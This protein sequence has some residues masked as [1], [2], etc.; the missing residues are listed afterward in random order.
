MI[1]LNEI[2]RKYS[3]GEN[4][5]FFN[6]IIDPLK[7]INKYAE[8]NLVPEN[9]F[10][11]NAFGVKIKEKFFPKI[12]QGRNGTVEGIPIPANWHSDVAEF[13][14]ALRAVDCA[15]NSFTIIELGCGWGCWMNITGVIAKRKGL[16]VNLIGIEGDT[17]HLEFA[18]EALRDNKFETS[19]F[20]LYNGVAASKGGT[21]LFPKQ[22]IA[23]E[24]WGLEPIFDVSAER[25][26][27][28]LGDN[29]YYPLKQYSIQ[30]IAGSH[31]RID[32]LHVDI[33]G[34]EEYLIPSSIS[35]LSDHV[36]YMFIGTHSRSIEGRMFD[37]LFKAGWVLEIER[38]A[39]LNVGRQPVTLVDGVQ[40]W[41]NPKLLPIVDKASSV[42]RIELASNV[43]QAI[44]NS[45]FQLNV[46][47]F[48]QSS[49]EWRSD[50]DFP[51]RVSY[52]WIDMN[53]K[54]IVAD[55][56]RTDLLGGVLLEDVSTVQ[57]INIT[58]PSQVGNYILLITLVQDGVAWFDEPDFKIIRQAVRILTP[59]T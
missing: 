28:L 57:S 34:G 20:T 13:G 15:L 5:L 27:Q 18:Q 56:I 46:K 17:G 26:E 42:G 3:A 47:I 40:G 19:E 32:L 22:N 31:Q 45:C 38:P 59:S 9:G 51:V 11:K 49:T 8:R 41:R 48:N 6:A 54:I 33:Q 14:A 16:K 4:F 58:A 43:S 12:L 55:G 35:F 7:L 53:G 24:N 36:A 52:R 37:C 44:V 2:K 10:L 39:V 1:T 30:E 29:K 50:G 25:V 23:G 21:A